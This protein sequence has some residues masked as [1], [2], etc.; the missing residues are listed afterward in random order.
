MNA[1]ELT[2]P[3]F[4]IFSSLIEERVGLCYG[5]QDRDL[6]ASK[7]SSRAQERGF[8]S[9]LDYYYFLRYDPESAQELEELTDNLVVNETF[10]LSGVCT[11]ASCGI[12]AFGTS[13]A[14]RSEATGVVR[15]L[16]YG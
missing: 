4:A 3:L 15:G 5:P 12:A 16:F 10:F 6:L 2:P 11:L 1:L 13:G 7:L 9:L 14:R 8:E